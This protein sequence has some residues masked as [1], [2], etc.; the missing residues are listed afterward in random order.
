MSARDLSPG[1]EVP[2]HRSLTEPIM[3]AGLVANRSL[4][5]GSVRYGIEFLPSSAS[6]MLQVVERYVE[7]R[8]TELL[9][10]FRSSSAGETA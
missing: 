6:R 8:Q 1:Y 10:R 9:E 4:S 5:P 2:I 3:L 7:D